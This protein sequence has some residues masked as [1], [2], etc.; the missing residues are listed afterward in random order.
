MRQGNTVIIEDRGVPVAR[1][2]P[3]ILAD[4][5]DGRVARLQRQGVVRAPS[6]VLS[7]T[8]LK[9]RPPRLLKGRTIVLEERAASR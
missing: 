3:V 5:A 9:A 7:P 6:G 1:L 8:W 4:D 2:E